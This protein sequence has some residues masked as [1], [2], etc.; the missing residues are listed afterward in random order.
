MDKY[1]IMTTIK[2]FN[3]IT[4]KFIVGTLDG[5]II[6]FFEENNFEPIIYNISDKLS[7]F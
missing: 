4:L 3:C 1:G 2:I 7:D 5:N 6:Y